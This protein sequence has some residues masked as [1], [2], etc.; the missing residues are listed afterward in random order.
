MTNLLQIFRFWKGVAPFW[1][2]E[3][4]Y[5]AHN[6]T[7]SYKKLKAFHVSWGLCTYSHYTSFF[8]WPSATITIWILILSMLYDVIFKFSGRTFKLTL[9]LN[10]RVFFSTFLYFLPTRRLSGKEKYSLPPNHQTIYLLHYSDF[11][12][13]YVPIKMSHF[14]AKRYYSFLLWKKHI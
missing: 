3:Y 6:Q 4:H 8:N 12:P 2:L 14:G 1:A 11:I 13:L 9:K 10:N 7:R 5:G